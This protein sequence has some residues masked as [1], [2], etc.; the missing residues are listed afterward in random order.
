MARLQADFTVAKGRLGINNPSQNGTV[1]SLRQELF[2]LLNDPDTSGDDKA[3]RQTLEQHI[4]PNVLADAEVASYCNNIR[5][6]DGSPVPGL[7]IPFSTT[8][9]HG[10][11]FFGLPLAGGDHTFSASN[12]ATKIY[13]AGIAFPGYVGMDAFAQGDPSGPVGSD[14]PNALSATPYVYL[15][16]CGA[17][18]MLAPA[19]G[20]ASV[21]RSW[22]VHDQAVPLPFNLGASDFNSN[23]FFSADGTLTEEPWILRKHPAF[24]AVSDATF[25]YSRVPAEFTSAR[26]VG[27]SAWN[28]RWKLVI[29]AY[30]LLDDEEAALNRFAATVED[31]Q[32]FLRTYSHS[33]N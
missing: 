17:D 29:P 24:R 33:G 16:P 21:L 6:R 10:R 22:T 8:I 12:F 9:E 27:R 4:V 7:I 23:Q 20:D 32:L 18:S 15:V 19:L 30:T 1:F 11:N 31:I 13:Q 5:K 14:A 3:W 25:F 2:R 26:L 28:N